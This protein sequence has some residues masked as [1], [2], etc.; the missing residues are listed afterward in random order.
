MTSLEQGRSRSA[1]TSDPEKRAM[2]MKNLRSNDNMGHTRI[3]SLNNGTSHRLTSVEYYDQSQMKHNT[4]TQAGDNFN[5]SQY[6]SSKDRRFDSGAHNTMTSASTTNMVNNSNQKNKISYE[7]NRHPSS[8]S[9]KDPSSHRRSTYSEKDGLRTNGEDGV[10]RYKSNHNSLRFI[11][12]ILG[13]AFGLAGSQLVALLYFTLGPRIAQDLNGTSLTVW[14]LSSGLVAMGAAAPFVGPMADLFGRKPIFL[15]GISLSILGAIICGFTPN[16][17]GF[18]A[19]Q[20]LLGLGGVIEELMALSI[21]T[22]IVPSEKRGLYAA[23]ILGAVLPWTP[24]TLYANFMASYSW[25]WISLPLAL[26]HLLVFSIILCFYFPPPRVNSANTTNRQLL[27]QIDWVGGFFLVLGSLLFLIGLNWGGLQ[28]PWKSPRVISFLSIGIGLYLIFALWEKY[29]AQF[30]LYP[31]RILQ[32]PRPFL[33]I[34]FVIFSAGINYIPLVVFWPIEAVAVHGADLKQSGIYSLPIGMC[35][36]GGAILSAVMIGFFKPYV[37]VIMTVFCVIQTSACAS[38]AASDPHNVSTI[39]APLCLALIGVG[40]VLVPN[41]IIITI[42]TPDDLIASATSLTV[43]VRSQAQVMG[44]AFFYSR[45]QHLLE[46][47]AIRHFA[48]PIISAGVYN[49]TVIK[50]L[51]LGLASHPFDELAQQIPQLAGPAHIAA[52]NAVKEGVIKSYKPTF[53]Y[54]Y[55]LSI[56]FG[57]AAC[58]AAAVMGNIEHYMDEHVAVSLS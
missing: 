3:D 22:E 45:F 36:V 4:N 19:G 23:M 33:C 6:N 16:A 21:V 49:I 53:D 17:A 8:D 11:M 15:V 43:A 32:A 9:A 40:G 58:I 50:D 1:T 34:M 46:K 57:A 18:I 27:K 28:Y 13:C 47:N 14:L 42:L 31:K 20:T 5:S 54:I 10:T 25:R 7:N 39:L 26:W 48:G 37:T 29:G 44:L 56:A 51:F 38:L 35:I 30:P 41:Q 12:T 52:F 2:E 55:L 24:G